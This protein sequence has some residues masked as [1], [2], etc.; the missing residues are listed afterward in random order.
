[1]YRLRGFLR[2][3]IAEIHQE[4]GAAQTDEVC[5]DAATTRSFNDNSEEFDTIIYFCQCTVGN[6]RKKRHGVR[7]GKF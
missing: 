2:G 4:A 3:I 1:M 7:G 6:L 5:K